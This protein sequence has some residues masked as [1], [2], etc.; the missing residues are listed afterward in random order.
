MRHYTQY[1]SLKFLTL[2]AIYLDREQY[3]PSLLQVISRSLNRARTES[4]AV[5]L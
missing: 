1:H 2:G 5:F 3:D 4:I